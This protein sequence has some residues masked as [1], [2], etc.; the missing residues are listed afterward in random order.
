MDRTLFSM[1]RFLPDPILS[2]DGHYLPFSDIYAKT[3][4]ED[5]P[6][7]KAKHQKSL[8]HSPSNKHAK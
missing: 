7:L 1:L 3:T 5:P 4:T 6:S 8:S 2:E